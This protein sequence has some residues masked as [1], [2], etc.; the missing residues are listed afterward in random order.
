MIEYAP[1]EG[2]ETWKVPVRGPRPHV[3][4]G[5]GFR[6]DLAIDVWTCSAPARRAHCDGYVVTAER[7]RDRSRFVVTTDET[8]C[9]P[10]S[11][12]VEMVR[13]VAEEYR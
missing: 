3:S 10:P 12:W 7:D 9:P 11:W 2:S 6:L 8:E 1:W 13:R 5:P 4:V